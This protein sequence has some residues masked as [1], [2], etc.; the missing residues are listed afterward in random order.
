[1]TSTR[2]KSFIV[3]CKIQGSI[4]WKYVKKHSFVWYW[5]IHLHTNKILPV[6]LEFFYFHFFWNNLKGSTSSSFSSPLNIGLLATQLYPLL[7]GAIFCRLIGLCRQSMFLTVV[8]RFS[9][10]VSVPTVLWILATLQSLSV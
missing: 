2:F 7:F 1:M 4:W 5:L 8:P 10:V 6:N 3:L 9:C